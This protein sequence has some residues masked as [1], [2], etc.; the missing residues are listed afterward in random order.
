MPYPFESQIRNLLEWARNASE[1]PKFEIA[2]YAFVAIVD[3]L[4]SSNPSGGSRRSLQAF[5]ENTSF[6]GGDM[7]DWLEELRRNWGAEEDTS[8]D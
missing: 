7:D 2:M 8:E 1:K 4:E 6:D 3:F 5:L